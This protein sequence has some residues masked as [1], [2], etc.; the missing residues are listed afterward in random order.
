MFIRNDILLIIKMKTNGKLEIKKILGIDLYL[1]LLI[2]FDLIQTTRIIY[3]IKDDYIIDYPS[4]RTI[5]S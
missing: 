5:G 3:T 2:I 4:H 1:I